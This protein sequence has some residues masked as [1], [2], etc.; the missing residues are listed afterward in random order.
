M[1]NAVDRINTATANPFIN[2]MDLVTPSISGPNLSY[3]FNA[4]I[5]S[6]NN[7]PNTAVDINN[8]WL[9]TNDKAII[10]PDNNATAV[11]ILTSVL[12]LS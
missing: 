5:N 7:A 10:A 9:S 12:A 2:A 8:F 4:P 3:N 1:T 11:A 6:T